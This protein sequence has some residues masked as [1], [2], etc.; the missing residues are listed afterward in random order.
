VNGS[1][2]D[3]LVLSGTIT[4]GQYT[5]TVIGAIS[6]LDQSAVFTVVADPIAA[7]VAPVVTVVPAG[8]GVV[9]LNP[10]GS[11]ITSLAQT[12]TNESTLM[13]LSAM[14]ALFTLVGG[15]ILVLRRKNATR[16]TTGTE[17]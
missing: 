5:V 2:T 11:S 1:I 8:S 7:P 9:A 15:A 4:P 10:T 3:V 16:V 12:G 13:G 14:A 6:G 17:S